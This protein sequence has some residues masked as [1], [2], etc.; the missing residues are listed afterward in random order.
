MSY[1]HRNNLLN[2]N[3]FNFIIIFLF[4]FLINLYYAKFGTFPIDTFLH[5]DSGYR[6]LNK[7]YPVKDYW[8]VSSF[9]VDFI[10]SLF[11]KIFGIN[12]YAYIFH[13]SFFN[14]II[15]LFTYYFFLHLKISK[16]NSLIFTLCFSTLAYT[17][18]GTPFVDL[19]ATFFSL[20]AT[21]LIIKNLGYLNNKYLLFIIVLL[22]FF[23]FLSKQV[24]TAYIVILEGFIII[25]FLVKKNNLE[26]L[27]F[28]VIN[29]ILCLVFFIVILTYLEID[30]K[31]FYLQYID[32][33]VSIGAL[34]FEIID[35]SFESLF[36]KYKYLFLP[37]VLI[38]FF[39]YKKLKKKEINLFSIEMFS[40]LIILAF[41]LG[42]LI[43]Q[44][45]TKNQI[46]IYFLVPILFA[47]IDVEINNSKLKYKKYLSILSIVCLVLITFKYHLRF[48]E[49]RKFHELAEINLNAAIA[50]E[51]IDNSLK[52]LLWINPLFK[53]DPN[54]EILLIKEATKELND[55][56]KE[57]M[58]I[59]H[60]SFLDS[61]TNKK[62][63]SP[64]KSFTFDG[65][66]MP[67]TKNKYY[68]KYKNFLANKIN[69]NNIKE[70]YFFKHEKIL[71]ETFT[72]YFKQE[73]YKLRENK[74]F[75]IYAI[76]CLK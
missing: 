28:I 13:S 7:E 75:Y 49:D 62:L 22:F 36:N 56:N 42:L 27:K 6:I 32:F 31:N 44:T 39:K 60:Y 8:I 76:K 38:S 2:L 10:Q 9:I 3:I 48:N 51:S 53:G 16:I 68:F 29:F 17:I 37:I 57:I 67:I 54:K 59:T 15:S 33:P 73:C 69:Q 61:I 64:N 63:H 5:Y 23:A 70:V 35:I 21:Y 47:L 18:S 20:I 40:F 24:P 72:A 71:N 50:A 30:Y 55:S 19:H 14:A 4:S 34:R 65:I 41:S 46:F 52:G 66:S 12:W 1:F 45:M 26:T 11:F 74:F 25:I 58:L 43:H